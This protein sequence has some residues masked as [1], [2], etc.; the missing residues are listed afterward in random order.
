MSAI[1]LRLQCVA[2]YQGLWLQVVCH[3]SVM[4]MQTKASGSVTMSQV[5]VTVKTTL[6]E[7]S[8]TAARMVTMAIRGKYSESLKM[9]TLLSCDY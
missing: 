2:I 9:S 3:A 7:N 1:L 5:T 6:R 8:V 4:A